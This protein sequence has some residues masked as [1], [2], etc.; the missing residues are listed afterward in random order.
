M[1]ERAGARPNGMIT[2]GHRKP[3]PTAVPSNV[4]AIKNS[5]EAREIVH[6][7]AFN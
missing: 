5:V 7:R 2:N 4:T 6:V 1:T 3:T